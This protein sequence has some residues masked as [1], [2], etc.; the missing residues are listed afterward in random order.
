MASLAI[1]M[2]AAIL[3]VTRMDDNLVSACEGTATTVPVCR[4]ISPFRASCLDLLMD[5]HISAP[6]QRRRALSYATSWGDPQAAH[7][8]DRETSM[9]ES[10]FWKRLKEQKAAIKDLE[11][12][13][14]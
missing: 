1:K 7:C 4:T 11:F 2:R 3:H 10:L 5:G 12:S 8:K 14:C 6:F 9:N 13:F